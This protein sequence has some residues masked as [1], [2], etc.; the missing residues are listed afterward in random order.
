MLVNKT[1]RDIKDMRIRG[2]LD[3]AI[4]ALRAMKGEVDGKSTAAVIKNLKKSGKMLKAARP[5]AVSLPNAVDY[6]LYLAGKNRGLSSK[7]FTRTMSEAIQ[8]FIDEQ[9]DSIEKIAD[10]GA[11]LINRDDVILTHCNSDTVV[12]L[13]RRA[14]GE[15]KRFSVICTETRPRFQ[16]HLTARA[17]VKAGIPTTLI[18]DSAARLM[19]KESRVDR[20]I[21][22]GDTIC[23]NGDLIN[24]IGTSQ[25]AGAA[26]ELDIDFISAV[27]S[28]KFSP[29]SVG[30]EMVK[31]EYRDAKEVISPG[32]IKGLRV[33]NPAFDITPAELID[34]FITEDGII[35]PQGAYQLLREK[36]GWELSSF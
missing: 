26:K 11:N 22:G 4:A 24:K 29:Q 20:V 14:W 13:L 35:P 25:I 9:K 10:I 21:V 2:A 6:V 12:A 19:M 31:I 32:K 27:E 3:I 8:K 36:F 17:L 5:T 16:G 7:E 23:A 28:I 18:V 33:L 15:G 34:M 30:G 1:V